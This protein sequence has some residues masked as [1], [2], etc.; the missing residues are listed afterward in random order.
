VIST[1]IDPFHHAAPL[2]LLVLAQRIGEFVRVSV[3][4]A[5]GADPLSDI[6]LP[7]PCPPAPRFPAVTRIDGT[8]PVKAKISNATWKSLLRIN[9]PS[10]FWMCR[11]PTWPEPCTQTACLASA[12]GQLSGRFED[13]G[14]SG[15]LWIRLVS[16]FGNQP[17]QM[18]THY[19]HFER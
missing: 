15:N 11:G 14:M 13:E 10:V 1:P 12:V 19:F 9:S 2:P 7:P 5:V 18:R 6:F 17:S 8:I 3:I 16:T 4:S